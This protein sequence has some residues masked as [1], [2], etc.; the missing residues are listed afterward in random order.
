MIPLKIL[1]CSVVCRP[2]WPL[3]TLANFGADGL[4]CC[5]QKTAVLGFPF[6]IDASLPKAFS[7]ATRSPSPEWRRDTLFQNAINLSLSNLR[8]IKSSPGG[9][10]N[11][12]PLY[13]PNK[14]QKEAVRNMNFR[15]GLKII[16][17]S[18]SDKKQNWSCI[19]TFGWKITF[20]IILCLSVMGSG[21]HTSLV[22]GAFFPLGLLSLLYPLWAVSPVS[23]AKK[24]EGEQ[25]WKWEESW[26]NG[27][28]SWCL[29]LSSWQ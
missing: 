29:T 16:H 1:F 27:A 26:N 3:I 19:S 25:C 7:P 12:V 2:T 24:R 17:A 4:L 9:K 13:S 11:K 8:F 18:F 20:C 21:Y 14:T 23:H 15:L 10:N 22:A 5:E 6:Q 28:V